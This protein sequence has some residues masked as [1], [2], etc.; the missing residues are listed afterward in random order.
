MIQ[1]ANLNHVRIEA[2]I[3]V[4]NPEPIVHVKIGDIVLL[5][6]LKKMYRTFWKIELQKGVEIKITR[7][8]CFSFKEIGK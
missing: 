2:H 4:M 5:G 7:K 1:A 6:T 3:D 8:Q